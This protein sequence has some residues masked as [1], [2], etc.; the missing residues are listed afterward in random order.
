MFVSPRMQG[1]QRSTTFGSMEIVCMVLRLLAVVCLLCGFA[2]YG[3][4]AADLPSGACYWRQGS[5]LNGIATGATK[6]ISVCRFV[7][8][9]PAFLEI[10]GSSPKL[11]ELVKTNAHEGG[12]WYPAKNEFYFSSGR[13]TG[14]SGNARADLKKV[15]LKTG[16]VTTLTSAPYDVPNG[17]VLDLEGNLIVC[18][19]GNETAGGFLQRINL[20]SLNRTVVADNWLGVPFNSPNDVVPK[21]DGSLWL[22]DPSYGSAQ[23]FRSAPKV[24]N[25]VY[26][27][28]AAGVVD[29]MAD[30]FTQPNGL[31]F[32]H[33]EKKLYVTDTGFATGL[34]GQFDVTRPHSVT[35][36]DIGEDGFLFNRR[37]FASIGVYDGSGPGLGIPDGIKVDTMERIYVATVDG[38][39]VFAKSG[40][41]LGLIRQPGTSNMGFAGKGL[42]TLY[43]L[44]DTTISYVT[45]KV[46][47]AG[48]QYASRTVE[49]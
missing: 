4:G 13:L 44:N 45:L 33:D 10:L 49:N 40:K 25:Q 31:A 43:L 1:G 36:F 12:V 20:K 17:M 28:S 9:D 21:S 5:L 11:E 32:S 27:V 22:T 38:V 23:G 24:N 29:A 35:V 42:D 34:A 37:L 39:Q 47:A 7:V 19:Q 26:R 16:A 46:K 14:P 2:A 6:D 3:E 30:G 18:Q 41:P 15:N 48:L 8:R